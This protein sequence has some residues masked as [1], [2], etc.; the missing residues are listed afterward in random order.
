MLKQKEVDKN[1]ISIFLFLGL[2]V[3]KPFPK[4]IVKEKM[5]L[6]AQPKKII[7]STVE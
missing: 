6:M 5:S 4:T 3:F 2:V 7:I 1:D